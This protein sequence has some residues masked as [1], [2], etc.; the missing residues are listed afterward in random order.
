VLFL[1]SPNSTHQFYLHPCKSQSTWK[2]SP[3]NLKPK[4][5]HPYW[6]NQKWYQFLSNFRTTIPD[7][8][9]NYKNKAYLS[10]LLVMKNE[11]IFNNENA[12]LGLK[13]KYF[14]I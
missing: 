10:C 7:E 5:D 4:Y 13:S 3:N 1:L 14:M 2:P 6:Q 9:I 11:V 8:Q 12:H